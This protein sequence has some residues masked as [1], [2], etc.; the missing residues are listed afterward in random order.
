M[1]GTTKI[2]MQENKSDTNN[3]LL[4]LFRA[5]TRNAVELEKFLRKRG[6][7]RLEAQGYT[8]PV[9]DPSDSTEYDR[10]HDEQGT[11]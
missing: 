4:A 11:P 8:I 7:A 9:I 2:T 10:F 5:N 6:T 3:Q 1:V